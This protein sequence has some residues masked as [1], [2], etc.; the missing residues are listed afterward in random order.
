MS[1]FEKFAYDYQINAANKFISSNRGLILYHSIGSGKTYTAL[2]SIFLYLKSN[3]N[4]KVI[5]ILPSS[6]KKLFFDELVKFKFP[7]K[8]KI[9]LYSYTEFINLN[10]KSEY[11][12]IPD[13]LVIDEAHRL[14]NTNTLT[15]KYIF[16]L[17]KKVDKVL[18]LTGTIIYN[19]VEDFLPLIKIIDPK[20]CILCGK[21]EFYKLFVEKQH[22][23][24]ITILFKKKENNLNKI[25]KKG[26]FLLKELSKNY[27]DIYNNINEQYP[28]INRN[29]I[30]I[31]MNKE[32]LEYYNSV[33]TKLPKKIYYKFLYGMPLKNKEIKIFNA[34][35]IVT[36]QICDSVY[37]FNGK[38]YSISSKIEALLNNIDKNKK[39]VIYSNF[40]EAG[41]A[42][43]EIT[44]N[45]N[46]IKYYTITGKT[47]KKSLTKIVKDFN[48]NT[49]NIL[50]ISSC[51]S[52]AITLK[53]VEIFHILEPHFNNA[54]INQ[55]I[56]RAYRINSHDTNTSNIINVFYYI[57]TLHKYR[58][59]FLNKKNMSIDE[60][61]YI[62]SYIKDNLTHNIIN[63]FKEGQNG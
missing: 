49:A 32:Q 41:I 12:I 29:V 13:I 30:Y 4:A 39:N 45:N 2:Y 43:V 47:D 5:V 10:K 58:L 26:V 7:F 44:L 61:L 3:L 46:N 1:V 56:G 6:F 36:R 17:S 8:E 9:I 14:R 62:N 55:V 22:F 63:Y 15:Y 57:S 60:L 31:E 40:I 54:K 28:S 37:P 11:N 19:S 24:F 27:M 51:A 53:N 50:I 59:S 23:N 16:E 25:S 20:S 18:L 48:N 38:K 35:S 42:P 52:E 21:K 34:F 33:Q